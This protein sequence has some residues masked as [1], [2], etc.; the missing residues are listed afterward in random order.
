MW[1]LTPQHKHHLD[2][3]WLAK[4]TW[5]NSPNKPNLRQ[6][7]K[8]QYTQKTQLKKQAT[9]VDPARKWSGLLYAG[10][11]T[12]RE[13]LLASR[14]A[15]FVSPARGWRRH[16][17]ISER[18]H[19]WVMERFRRL[20][21]TELDR[22]HHQPRSA[23]TGM[24]CRKQQRIALMSPRLS[25]MWVERRTNVWCIRY[26][27]QCLTYSQSSTGSQLSLLYEFARWTHW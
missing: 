19:Q 27:M 25:L 16:R 15:H 17:K 22:C 21:M 1:K 20:T 6:P 3:V 26:N 13:R 12:T 24:R 23:S 7:K 8:N 18:A 14:F 9:L 10:P 4:I 5:Q 2:T 11:E